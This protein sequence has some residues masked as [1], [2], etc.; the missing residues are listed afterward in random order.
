M[1]QHILTLGPLPV[2]TRLPVVRRPCAVRSRM[3]TMEGFIMKTRHWGVLAMACLL[4]G[5]CQDR[6]DPVKPTTAA[7]ATIPAAAGTAG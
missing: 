5:A 2:V 1:L 4:L 6:R 3:A 7:Q